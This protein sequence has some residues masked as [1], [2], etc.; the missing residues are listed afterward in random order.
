MA[1]NASWTHL[2]GQNK[3]R[4]GSILGHK[5]GAAW[6]VSGARCAI[7][8]CVLGALLGSHAGIVTGSTGTTIVRLELLLHGG[9]GQRALQSSRLRALHIESLRLWTLSLRVLRRSLLHHTLRLLCVISGRI[10]TCL[11]ASQ[12]LLGGT[13]AAVA[14]A[15]HIGACSDEPNAC[16]VGAEMC[17]CRVIQYEVASRPT[18]DARRSATSFAYVHA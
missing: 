17:K 15:V 5:V 3:V 4:I 18:P 9:S 2:R 11:L 10:H 13:Y 8:G 14:A 6:I 12:A 16:G 7:F 1:C